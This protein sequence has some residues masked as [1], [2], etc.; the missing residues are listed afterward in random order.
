MNVGMKP[1]CHSLRSVPSGRWLF[2]TL[3]PICN[4]DGAKVEMV[5]EMAWT[6][7]IGKRVL[8]SKILDIWL[9][10]PLER[11]FDLGMILK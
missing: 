9:K 11:L 4:S 2:V 10:E 3:P 5:G 7:G 6:K 1:R 8:E